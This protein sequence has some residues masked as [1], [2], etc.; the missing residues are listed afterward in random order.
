MVT[1]LIPFVPLL[2][3]D[4]AFVGRYSANFGVKFDNN[5][6]F[7]PVSIRDVAELHHSKLLWQFLQ[8]LRKSQ[9][10]TRLFCTRIFD[11]L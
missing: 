3:C 11:G 4:K 5:S 2:S 9:R 7:R 10:F 1:K 6:R 8:L